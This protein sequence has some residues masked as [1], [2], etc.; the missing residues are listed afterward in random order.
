MS[1]LCDADYLIHQLRLTYLRHVEDPYGPR[2]LSLDPA[3]ASNPNILASGLAD[4][5]V[6]PE[7]VM[8]STPGAIDLEASKEASKRNSGF[9][10]AGLKYSQT[11]VGQNRTGGMGMRVHAKRGSLIRETPPIITEPEANGKRNRSDSEPTPVQAATSPDVHDLEPRP[12]KLGTNTLLRR[13]SIDA[14][15]LEE[16]PAA[17]EGPTK[18]QPFNPPF[19]RA[20]EMEERRALRMRSRFAT[21]GN[22]PLAI[23]VQERQSMNPEE[24]DEDTV[25]SG[26]EDELLTGTLEAE[27][28]PDDDFFDTSFGPRIVLD[29][30]VSDGTLSPGNSGVSTSHSSGPGHFNPNNLNVVGNTRRPRLSPVHEARP[31]AMIIEDPPTPPQQSSDNLNA[32][33]TPQRTYKSEG[34]YFELV[35]P[36]SQSKI[37][38]SVA[39]DQGVKPE[40]TTVVASPMGAPIKVLGDK[41]IEE[42][43]E[44]TFQRVKVASVPSRATPSGL[45]LILASKTSKSDNPFAELYSL[46]SSRSNPL[47][48]E[49]TYP[50]SNPRKTVTLQARQDAT[51][52]EVIGFALW[53]YWEEGF[54]PKLDEIDD[55]R[56]KDRLSAAGWSLRITEDGDVDDD[57]PAMDRMARMSGSNISHGPQQFLRIKIAEKADVHYST[58]IPVKENMYMEEVLENACRRRR[59]DDPKEWCLVYDMEI[60]VPLDRTV[61]S[62]QGKTELFLV[63]RENLSQYQIRRQVTRSTDPNASIFSRISEVPEQQYSAALDFTRAYKKYTVWR[64]MPML[65][66]R[67]E[68]TLAIDGD[69]IHIMPP[70]TRAFLDN[71]KTSS[72][73]IRSVVLCMQSAKASSNFKLIVWRDGSNKRYD[74][75]AESPKM[76]AEIV[77]NIKDLKTKRLERSSTVN[78][79][80]RRSRPPV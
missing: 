61:A 15:E 42:E 53:T 55:T 74:F 37:D 12:A 14:S 28:A 11:I 68:R 54:T 77:R 80:S 10:G 41:F 73:H 49:I 34:S 7:L 27:D 79:R 3:Y 66:V 56:K 16:A 72:Y 64:K 22:A 76:A 8:P 62:L 39:D 18:V 35:V 1:L 65:V 32:N 75:E 78:P 20:K 67:H 48:L 17:N 26:E 57:F 13:T 24:S 43:E 52:E 6:W 25:T 29:A 60:L 36:P 2:T 4:Q 31:H 23:V 46:I 45:S 9:P 59:I 30:S 19:A 47:S 21:T 51:V 38:Q 63:K 71:M 58:T 69:Y 5:D 70:P 44:L 40:M 50:I 33:V